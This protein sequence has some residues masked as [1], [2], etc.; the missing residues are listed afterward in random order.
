MLKASELR[1]VS[2][3]HT[4]WKCQVQDWVQGPWPHP[5]LPPRLRAASSSSHCARHAPWPLP[6]TASEDDTSYYFSAPILE[7]IPSRQTWPSFWANLEQD[8]EEHVKDIA[9]SLLLKIHKPETWPMVPGSMW[10]GVWVEMS[11]CI[12][13][14]KSPCGLIL[15]LQLT[16]MTPSPRHLHSSSLEHDPHSP[17]L[18]AVAEP[19]F[20]LA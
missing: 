19:Q 3:G 9:A 4:A 14:K 7:P 15:E 12:P 11:W 16:Q 5:G 2:Q 20:P 1:I 6:W 18:L 8:S 10:V 17:A 13:G